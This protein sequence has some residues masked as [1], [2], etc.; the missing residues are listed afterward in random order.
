METCPP[1]VTAGLITAS[2]STFELA[3]QGNRGINQPQI[4]LG[5]PQMNARSA[6]VH[7]RMFPGPGASFKAE[8]GAE[9][10]ILGKSGPE[11]TAAPSCIIAPKD[12]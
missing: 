3:P 10:R 8:K 5:R 12:T 2:R 11:A 4:A 1:L 6:G 7:L 9:A